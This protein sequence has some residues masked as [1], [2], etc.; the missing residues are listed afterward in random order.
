MSMKRYAG[1][2]TIVL[3][4]AT[5]LTACEEGAEDNAAD[6]QDQDSG[7]SGNLV[8]EGASSQQNAI[9]LFI[10]RYGEA[11]SN[12]DVSYTASGSGSG[13]SNF[14]GGQVNFAGSDSPLD[15][16][17]AADA[18]D[19]CGGADAW[20]LPFVIGPVAIAFNLDG[21]DELNLSTE[22][23]ARIFNGDITNWNDEAIAAEN[24][25]VELPDEG[26]QVVYRSDE[27][28]TS[29]NFQKFLSATAPEQWEGSGKAFP[30]EVGS[31][32]NGSAGVATEVS[33]TPGA[34]TYVEAGFAADNDLGIANIDFGSGPTELS[35]ETVNTALD[36]VEFAG[37]GNDMV[38]DSEALFAMNEEGAYPLV[39]T[40]YEIV[41]SDYSNANDPEG[42]ADLLKEFLENALE[43]QQED[44]YLSAGFIPVETGSAH[45]DRLATA[46][47]EIQ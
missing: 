35:S 4:S 40:T 5:A 7:A 38:V 24:E 21:V 44:A 8:G 37:E 22:T 17:E 10:Q 6:G 31:G 19:R 20:H 14:I 28:G 23:V 18:Q 47:S 30:T 34:I 2:A 1:I 13:V 26:I 27:S 25:G 41:C 45:Y 11:N 42:T 29:D 39:L 36:N 9:D 32:A 15:E 33:Q 3:A 12:A 43:T 46:I 16:E